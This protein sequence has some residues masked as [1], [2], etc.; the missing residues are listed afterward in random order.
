MAVLLLRNSTLRTDS[1]STP[2]GRTIIDSNPAGWH[3]V[4]L[5]EWGLTGAEWTDRHPHEE[6]NYVLEGEL[7]VE[8]EGRTI[9]AF[10]GDTVRVT[11]GSTGRY[12]APVH[13]RMLAIYGPNPEGLAS[14]SFA[15]R[16]L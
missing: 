10:T 14:D 1:S 7:H 5:T 4:A 12:F 6:I 15:Y 3:G 16:K 2:P 8:S 9:V 11:P 13:A